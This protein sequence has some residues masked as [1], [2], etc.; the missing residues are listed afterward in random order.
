MM[1][2]EKDRTEEKGLSVKY[3]VIILCVLVFLAMLVWGYNYYRLKSVKVEGLTRYTEEE[4]REKLENGVLTSLTPFFCL[5]DILEQ[6]EIP[7]IEKYEIDYVDRQT[8]RVRVHEKRITGCVIIMGRYMFFDKDGIVVESSTELPEGIPVVTG[9]EFN[10]IVLYQ[11]L[12]VQKQSLF[13]VILQLTRLTEQNKI[14]VQEI[15]FDS[16]Y[17]VTLYVGD[18]TV[19]LGKKINY[20]EEMNALDGILTAMG[21]RTGNLDMR[22]YSRENGEVILKEP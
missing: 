12:N 16:N 19:L 21:G 15:S 14:P 7:F 11:K 4:F 6:K 3:M 10:E 18:I 13:D 8:A 20:D 5:S 1:E 22:N 9:L 17:E 2:Q